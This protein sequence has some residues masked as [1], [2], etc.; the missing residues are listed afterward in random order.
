MLGIAEALKNQLN[1]KELMILSNDVKQ[2]MSILNSLEQKAKANM[3]S[4][5]LELLKRLSAVVLVIQNDI[6]KLGPQPEPPD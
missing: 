1:N 4:A 3:K 5:S 2:A 6:N